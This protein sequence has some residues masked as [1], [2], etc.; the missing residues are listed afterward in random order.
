METLK[1]LSAK[2]EV[3]LLANTQGED[4]SQNIDA[5]ASM[6]RVIEVEYLSSRKVDQFVRMAKGLL[7]GSSFIQSFH[8]NRRLADRISAITASEQFDIVQIELSFLARYAAAIDPSNRAK[9]VLSTHNIETQRFRR[10]LRLTSWDSRHL[11]LRADEMLFPRWEEHALQKC[12]GALAVSDLDR[13]WIAEQAP[14]CMVE[15][16]PN[17]VDVD[18][19]QPHRNGDDHKPSIAFTGLMDY[20]P[21]VDAVCWF[22]SE[23]FPS[24]KEAYPNLV[25]QIVG[26]RPTDEVRALGD[27]D[28]VEVTG[29]VPDVRP[30]IDHA[31]AFV[32]PL[33]SGG[34][35]RLK[36]LQAMAMACPVI[37]T[38]VGA[39]GLNVVDDRDILFAEDSD[40]FVAQV[41]KLLT[42]R[43]IGERIGKAG[44]DL[45][46]AQYD[47][48]SCLRGLDA[49]YIRV[50]DDSQV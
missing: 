6:C 19:F 15:L 29:E 41:G 22:V 3:T 33:R 2:H 9:V 17:G 50:L 26:A 25:F 12:D 45:V 13:E 32:V 20:P 42:S 46:H 27:F 7:S 36:I 28:G 11:V 34:G 30:F 4:E 37:S 38:R 49:L 1:H 31:M 23:I 5:I 39:E 10:E 40:Q 21:N 47:W 48:S 16:A 18:F 44:Y 8:Y 35:T 24:V 14:R 43:N